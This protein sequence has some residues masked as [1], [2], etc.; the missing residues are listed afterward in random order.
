MPNAN[1]G[2][3][4]LTVADKTY[5]LVPS[6]QT[7]AEIENEVG[8]I[9]VLSAKIMSQTFTFTEILKI[10][11]IAARHSDAKPADEKT[12]MEDLY[13]EGVIRVG[14][15]AASQLIQGALSTGRPTEK[16]KSTA[17]AKT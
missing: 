11:A 16:G 2:E 13:A 4:A 14:V 12:F 5:T 8:S 15:K 9:M 6:M 3:V 17:K 1:R 10:C 7:I